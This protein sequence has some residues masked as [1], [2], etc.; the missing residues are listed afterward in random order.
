MMEP[1]GDTV[2]VIIIDNRKYFFKSHFSVLID[3]PYVAIYEHRRKPFVEVPSTVELGR[4]NDLAGIHIDIS[5]L[6]VK[7]PKHNQTVL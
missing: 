4:D 3:K 6:V 1:K 7:R 2:I 5:T